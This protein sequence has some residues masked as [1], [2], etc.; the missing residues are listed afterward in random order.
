[1][2]QSEAFGAKWFSEAHQN[3][4]ERSW[5]ANPTAERSSR[6]CFGNRWVDAMKSAFDWI[7]LSQY[8]IFVSKFRIFQVH[9]SH[10]TWLTWFD[11]VYGA[12]ELHSRISLNFCDESNGK[13]DS[14]LQKKRF[15][16]WGSAFSTQIFADFGHDGHVF[17]IILEFNHIFRKSF[18]FPC[19]SHSFCH[20][21]HSTV[22]SVWWK[23][24]PWTW[25]CVECTS[26]D[27]SASKV[28]HLQSQK[29]HW[30][31][32]SNRCTTIPSSS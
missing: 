14:C 11:L 4:T 8:W 17:A 9:P 32:N 15:I 6:L 12:K 3:R 19:K 29:F 28:P 31:M 10:G 5:A 16:G 2:S 23:S 30:R 22:E 26:L 1:M 13:Y 25:N 7:R 20:F 24:W 21:I 18:R 27:S